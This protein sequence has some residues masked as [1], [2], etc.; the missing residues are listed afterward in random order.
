MELR[1]GA[2]LG[3]LIGVMTV[4]GIAICSAAERRL[5]SGRDPGMIVWDEI[6]GQALALWL[7]WAWI[8][9]PLGA[10]GWTVA[11]LVGVSFLSFRIFDIS[12]W[13]VVGWCDRHCHGGFG[14]MLDDIAAAVLAALVTVLVYTMVPSLLSL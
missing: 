1:G 9:V 5:S 6:V 14:M 8:G 12:K 7:A 2:I 4:A 10:S 11:C 3:G 13:W